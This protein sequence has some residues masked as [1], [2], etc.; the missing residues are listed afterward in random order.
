MNENHYTHQ[1][2]LFYSQIYLFVIIPATPQVG[3]T[4]YISDSSLV[5]YWKLNM[6]SPGKITSKWQMF[7]MKLSVISLHHLKQLKFKAWTASMTVLQQIPA[8]AWHL[9]SHR[10][11]FLFNMPYW[12][13]WSKMGLS[14][15]P[16]NRF[17]SFCHPIVMAVLTTKPEELRL[18]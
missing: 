18:A 7:C 2:L 6:E 10:V 5:I 8:V 15:I 12:W 9:W 1:P 4:N 11:D 17:K 3:I 13:G 16:A 14:N